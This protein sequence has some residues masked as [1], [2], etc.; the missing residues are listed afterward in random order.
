M[1]WTRRPE[2]AKTA[3]RMATLVRRALRHM[4]GRRYRSVKRTLN[5]GVV[6]AT[7]VGAPMRHIAQTLSAVDRIH[8][9]LALRP[10]TKSVTIAREELET[11]LEFWTSRWRQ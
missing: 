2:A 6:R 7:L 4:E 1:R 8:A 10:D 5:E 3:A 9:R 11:L